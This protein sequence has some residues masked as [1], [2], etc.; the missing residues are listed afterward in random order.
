MLVGVHDFTC[1]PENM[2]RQR[3]AGLKVNRPGLVEALIP[4]EDEEHGSTEEVPR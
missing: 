3:H 1:G 2:C 4:R